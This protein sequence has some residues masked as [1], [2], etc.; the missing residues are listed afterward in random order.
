MYS[1]FPV[2]FILESLDTWRNWGFYTS[3]E[4]FLGANM[5]AKDG[6]RKRVNGLWGRNRKTE[7]HS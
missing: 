4:S 7:V 2:Y 6:D 1:S 5:G 3:G